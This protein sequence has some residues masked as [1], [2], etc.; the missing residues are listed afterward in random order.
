MMEWEAEDCSRV[1]AG[2]CDVVSV[3]ARICSSSLS[4]ATVVIEVVETCDCLETEE[5]FVD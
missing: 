1:L 3:E 2:R 5:V 4:A